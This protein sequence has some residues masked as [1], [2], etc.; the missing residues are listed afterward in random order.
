MAPATLLSYR[1]GR[2]LP[3]L[4]LIASV[5][6]TLIGCSAAAPTTNGSPSVQQRKADA[7][8][9]QAAAYGSQGDLKR[10][11]ELLD[12]AVRI[13]PQHAVAWA[14]RATA[15][16]KLGNFERAI[17]DATRAIEINPKFAE[18]YCQ[19]AFAY[20]QSQLD[21]RVEHS[22]ADANKAIE[23]NPKYPLSFIV[24]GNARLE[25]EEYAGAIA[26]FTKAI[27]FNPRSYS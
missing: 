25:L 4:A 17:Q 2:F 24:R 20:Q 5:L 23:L 8:V 11:V 10:A 18:A 19:R 22:L 13:D 1:R 27:E 6:S 14:T 7:L 15:F 26:D 9:E 21:N 16:R 12:E 3:G